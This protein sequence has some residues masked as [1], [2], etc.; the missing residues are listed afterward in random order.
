M[1]YLLEPRNAFDN[2]SADP[3]VLLNSNILIF[4]FQPK[5]VHKERGRNITSSFVET[6]Y[7]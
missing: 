1:Y 6:K 7:R 4:A 3:K 5:K 2:Q